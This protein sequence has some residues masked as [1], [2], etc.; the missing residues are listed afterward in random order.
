MLI[1]PY[2]DQEGNK[3]QRPNPNFCKPLKKKFRKLSVQP[4]LRGSNDLHVGRKMAKFQLFFF[5]WVGLRTYQH[6]CRNNLTLSSNREIHSVLLSYDS[7]L[8]CNRFKTLRR[9]YTAFIFR[10]PDTSGN[11]CQVTRRHMPEG[12]LN[13][14]AIEF[15]RLVYGGRDMVNCNWTGIVQLF[16]LGT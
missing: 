6:P 4:G 12:I 11:D 15:S 3:L 14:A 13:Q 16:Q 9:G 5:S 1:S 8:L 10:E 7:A 2:P